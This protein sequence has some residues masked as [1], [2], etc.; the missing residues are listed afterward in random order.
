[1]N[2][3]RYCSFG[4]ALYR[5]GIR[6]EQKLVLIAEQNLIWTYSNWDIIKS[7]QEEASRFTPDASC[8]TDGHSDWKSFLCC[9]ARFLMNCKL[10]LHFFN[11]SSSL[12][13]S[14]CSVQ[15]I[16]C[17]SFAALLKC[18]KDLINFHRPFMSRDKISFL[19]IHREIGQVSNRKK[20][21]EE[22]F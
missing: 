10:Q 13:V 15:R 8:C 7:C 6:G 18:L 9:T 22:I 5:V 4:H 1:M 12:N 14:A 3:P 19:I 2:Y 16:A 11:Q 17:S 21:C 20:C